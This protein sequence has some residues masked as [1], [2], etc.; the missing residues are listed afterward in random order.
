ML[1]NG[2]AFKMGSDPT[3]NK[4]VET[5][6][7]ATTG[8]LDKDSNQ[9]EIITSVTTSDRYT[10]KK[11]PTVPNNKKR[12][13]RVTNA[14][15]SG[16]LDRPEDCCTRHCGC[17]MNCHR[18]FDTSCCR[19][20]C[21]RRRNM[22]RKLTLTVPIRSV[23]A[24]IVSDNPYAFPKINDDVTEYIIQKAWNEMALYHTETC[25]EVHTMNDADVTRTAEL[26]IAISNSF[27]HFRKLAEYDLLQTVSEGLTSCLI[28]L[29]VIVV[30]LGGVILPLTIIYGNDLP[31]A[32]GE[33]N[34]FMII[35]F[36]VAIWHP[37][38]LL[39][40]GRHMIRLR[41]QICHRL[42]DASCE[43]LVIDPFSDVDVVKDGV[44]RKMNYE[45]VDV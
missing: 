8:P 2:T 9:S 16:S 37:V 12:I 19:F 17:R 34:S 13:M 10:I 6:L 26:E 29:G 22:P 15:L 45:F 38:E 4:P 14:V 24:L 32:A 44:K 31:T 3:S 41:M 18:V 36:W 39:V 27:H 25:I 1:D 20:M 43:I 35:V 11:L 21:R 40:Y 28:S 42:S 5:I 33:V 23:D 7:I 30:T